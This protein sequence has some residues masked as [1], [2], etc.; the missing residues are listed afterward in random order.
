MADGSRDFSYAVLQIDN[1]LNAFHQ[2]AL[3]R[4]PD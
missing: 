3:L 4:G 2:A 1:G